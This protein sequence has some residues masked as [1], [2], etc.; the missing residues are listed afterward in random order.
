MIQ[1]KSK[2]LDVIL[3]LF[4]ISLQSPCH[5][6]MWFWWSQ[7]QRPRVGLAVFSFF[8]FLRFCVSATVVINALNVNILSFALVTEGRKL[9]DDSKY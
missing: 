5:A 8:C 6:F 4:V 2:E 1:E 3:L 9:A 7:T